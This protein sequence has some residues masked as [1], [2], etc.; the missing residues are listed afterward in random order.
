MKWHFQT[1]EKWYSFFSWG[2]DS[3]QYFQYK[4]LP[5]ATAYL[6]RSG[7]CRLCLSHREGKREVMNSFMNTAVSWKDRLHYP[8]VACWGSDF[9][10]SYPQ[11]NGHFRLTVMLFSIHS[12]KIVQSSHIIFKIWVEFGSKDVFQKRCFLVLFC[13]SVISK[14]SKVQ[15]CWLKNYQ[16][17]IHFKSYPSFISSHRGKKHL[18]SFGYSDGA[19]IR[20]PLQK[21]E[22]RIM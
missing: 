18:L 4:A 21:K 6:F 16:L 3:L 13:C 12:F 7:F 19:G 9:I 15:I 5:E 11:E 22:H 1:G 2:P 10:Y 14:K 20:R 8:T 17:L